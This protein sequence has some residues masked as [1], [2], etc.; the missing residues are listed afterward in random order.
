M[1][2]TSKSNGF[3]VLVTGGTGFV[4]SAVVNYLLGQ[5]HVSV[6]NVGKLTYA[7]NLES[8]SPTQ[9]CSP[10]PESARRARESV[11]IRRRYP[12]GHSRGGGI[13]SLYDSHMVPN[14]LRGASLPVY[15]DGRQIRDWLYVRADESHFQRVRFELRQSLP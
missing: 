6:V 15:G 4:G 10:R 8:L 7:G 5:P 14:A 9:D 12:R 3:K 11:P 1:T 13:A 2:A